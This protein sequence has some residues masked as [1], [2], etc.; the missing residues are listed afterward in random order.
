MLGIGAA[1]DR[2]GHQDAKPSFSKGA[3]GFRLLR[4]D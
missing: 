1:A 3:E 2:E 4:K